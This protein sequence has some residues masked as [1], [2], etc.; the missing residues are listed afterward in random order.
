MHQE[1]NQELFDNLFADVRWEQ[2]IS[3]LLGDQKLSE[4]Q[5]AALDLAS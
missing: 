2:A 4:K 5:Q 3:L 1:L